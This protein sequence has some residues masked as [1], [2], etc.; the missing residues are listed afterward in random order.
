MKMLLVST[1]GT[2]LLTNV[3]GSDE[4]RW[5]FAHANDSH[6]EGP[7]QAA[8]DAMAASARER[9]SR[10]DPKTRVQMSAEY[11]GMAACHARWSPEHTHHILIH[12]DTVVG[13]AAANV[14]EAVLQ[15]KHT[16]TAP[17]LRTSDLM[18]FR[19]A[20]AQLT[21][22]LE[23]DLAA[24]RKDEWTIVFNL[25]GGFKS[26]I[27]Y[28]QA[29]GMH[30]ADH[31]VYVF[32]GAELMI[33][34]R[35]PVGFTENTTV[36]AHLTTFRKLAVGYC[37]KTQDADAISKTLVDVIDD[38]VTTSVWGDVIWHRTKQQLLGSK[39]L[40][41]LSRRVVLSQK[42]RDEINA[43]PKDRI[44]LVNQTL[45]RFCHHLDTGTPLGKRDTFKGIQ[46]NPV[47]G[48]THELYA[49]SDGE[50]GRLFGRFHDDKFLVDS[51]RSHL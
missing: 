19:A 46:G 39:A 44:L 4:R 42:A 36:E 7:D 48:S 3:A 17:G 47:P 11:A 31:C 6:L 37:V 41:P 18:E 20:L 5:L 12:T 45:D 27:G 38:E 24:W 28:L 22:A 9:F 26:L 51:L 8:V 14:V 43:K 10:A 25:T 34:P 21:L 33:I 30:Y 16:M 13:R 35:L 2:S 29:L 15:R 50:T 40:D 23:E 49:W 1:C 32:H